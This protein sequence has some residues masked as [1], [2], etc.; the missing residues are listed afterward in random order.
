MKKHQPRFFFR[1][2][3]GLLL[4]VLL[5]FT[6]FS[7]R[8]FIEQQNRPESIT[9]EFQNEWNAIASETAKRVEFLISEFDTTSQAVPPK[10]VDLNP[11]NDNDCEIF[12]LVYK[13]DTLVYWNNNKVILPPEFSKT[14]TN[15]NFARQ[16]QTGWYG[17]HCQQKGDYH[18]LGGY[19]IKHEYPFQNEYLQNRFSS[20]FDIPASISI[21]SKIGSYP[22]INTGKTFIFSLDFSNYKAHS[23]GLVFLIFL[24]FI[25]GSLCLYYFLFRVFSLLS[26][27]K[28]RDNLLIVSYSVSLILLR[29]IQDRSGFPAE[30]Y[31]S[32]LFSPAWYSSSVFLPSLG[33]FTLNALILFV[34]SLVFFKKSSITPDT[35]L[36]RQSQRFARNTFA[37]III[38]M[39]FQAVGYFVSDLVI[40]SSLSLN[41]QNVSGLICESGFGLFIATTMLFSLWLVST[42]VF[43]AISFTVPPKKW[44]VLSVFLA[45]GIFS[46]ACWLAGWTLNLTITLF[47]IL[48][49]TAYWYIKSRKNV[50]FTIQNLIFFL[51][52]YAILGTV[53]LK[54]ANQK[55]ETEKL[56]LWAGKLVTQQNPVT[57]VLFEQVERRLRADSLLNEWMQPNAIYNSYG[58]D[59]LVNYL[60]TRY[61]KDYWRKYQI[62]ITY[63]EPTKNLRIQPQGY[64][65]NCSAYF[66][67]IINN[68]GKATS[69]PG[70]FFLDYGF[71]KEYYLA[72]FPGMPVGNRPEVCPALFI[73]FN[74]RNAYPDPGYPGLLMDKARLVLPNLS[75]YS[76]GLFHD[77][78]LIRAA[79]AWPYK[80]ELKK[81]QS[82]SAEKSSFVEDHMIHYQYHVN[83]TDTLLISKPEDN[84]LSFATP[85]SYLFL[86]FFAMALLVTAIVHFPWN[87]NFVP[88][89]LRNRLHF[90]LIGI[91]LVTILAIGIVQINNIIQINL[92]K[93]VDNLREKAYSMVIEVQHK[94]SL[95]QEIRDVANPEL[96]DF[97]V[98][99]SNVFFTDINVYSTN[100]ILVASSRPQIFEEG[101]LSERM[102]AIAFRNLV[103]EKKSIFIH[104]ESIG[105]MQFNSAYLPFYND[106][107]QLLGFVNLPSFARQDEAKK[108]ISSFLV[109]FVNIYILLILFGIFITVLI[110]NYITAPLAML[111]GKMSQLRLGKVNEKIPWKQ[112]DEIGQLVSE[113]NRMID[114]LGRSAEMLARSER[115]SAW[116]EM[117]KQV[118]HEI[119][120]PLTPMK[121]SV[122]YLEKAWNEKAPDW[123]Q[124]LS[125][126]TKTLVAQIDALSVIASDFSDF[127]KMPAVVMEKIDMEEV[128]RF[129]LSLYQETTPISYEFQNE[130]S[131][132]IITGDRSQLIRL[133]TN[134]LNNAVQAIGDR[135]DGVIRIHIAKQQQ[136]IVVKLSDNGCG[137]SPE[138]TDRIFQPDFTTKTSGMGLGLAIVKGILD[139]MNGEI[140]FT[141][142][143]QKGTTFFIKFP[144]NDEHE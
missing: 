85:F 41:L 43:D 64:L 92:K 82:F 139:G 117:A 115:E 121:L 29:L 56:N 103:V 6:V 68:Y 129:V 118:A 96:A 36:I 101:L 16:M 60:K 3:P 72:V 2:I 113:Y 128:I 1:E 136:S 76:Y 137:I 42:K 13:N 11:G 79:G 24:L 57:E 81:F 34:I 28:N 125:R 59:S 133:F 120:N 45:T 58:Q 32:E 111:A 104:H 109:T 142:E 9:L 47:F 108:E 23:E 61:F 65:I 107:D 144:E 110:S 25:V 77:G 70:L 10:G 37:L 4:A 55:K 5:F 106:H 90:S 27:F 99:L 44:L 22:I 62:Q 17:F 39:F 87:F 132:P 33:D 100:G 26:W 14:C 74:L 66:Q 69:L 30:I 94:Y 12:F 75:D 80:T 126:F 98:K 15:D 95:L 38:L 20:R 48:Y 40:N 97:L 50:L 73:E 19:L 51:C 119:K 131:E 114:E 18:F 112:N 84:F 88:V 7:I 138:R 135:S 105:S 134:L 127:A 130:V 91:L 140:S 116:R 86:L 141:S 67:G 54:K 93:N 122:Q 63:C 89:T 31:R 53:L 8:Q 143:E 123:D 49:F 52:F 102:N 46:L 78:K 124:R 35:S 83:N 71:G 21:T